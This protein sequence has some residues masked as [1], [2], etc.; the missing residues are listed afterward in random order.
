MYNPYN[1]YSYLYPN[2]M[3]QV[4]FQT[5]Q[6]TFQNTGM[7]FQQ[8]AQQ[9]SASVPVVIPVNTIKQVEQAPVQPGGKALILVSN[10]PVIA[11]RTADNMGITSTDY[12][13]IEKFDPESTENATTV[14]YVTR[15]EFQKFIDSLNV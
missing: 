12:Y 13:H 11:M 6:S 15:E 14:E 5:P 8:N 10:E 4:P 1:P 3:Q 2:N 9:T 7:N